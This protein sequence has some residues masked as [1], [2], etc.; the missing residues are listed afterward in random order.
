MVGVHI[1]T[2]ETPNWLWMTYW[3]SSEWWNEHQGFGSVQNKWELFKVNATANNVDPVANPYLEG[4]NSGM[5]SNCLECHRH[6]VYRHGGAS[7]LL[8]AQDA[9]TKGRFFKGIAGTDDDPPIPTTFDTSD[10]LHPLV[11]QTD[12]QVRDLQ[13]PACYFADA[14]QTHF[15]WSVALNKASPVSQVLCKTAP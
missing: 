14:L 7:D 8:T 15:L 5:T 6:A 13:Q 2:R 9:S 10:P 1:M 4:P 3:W 12:P 11:K